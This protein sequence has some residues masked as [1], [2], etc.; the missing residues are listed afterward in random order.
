MIMLHITFN[1]GPN[2]IWLITKGYVEIVS[3]VMFDLSVDVSEVLQTTS[4]DIVFPLLARSCSEMIRLMKLA[5]N[6]LTE[7]L[8]RIYLTRGGDGLR[9][10]AGLFLHC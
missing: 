3:D 6:F 2:L 7:H 4:P 9:T 8:Y 10:S 5:F 1:C